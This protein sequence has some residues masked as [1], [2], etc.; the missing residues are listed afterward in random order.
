MN[1][2][3]AAE[4]ILIFSGFCEAATT[5]STVERGLIPEERSHR[6]AAGADDKWFTRFLSPF[7]FFYLQLPLPLPP[8]KCYEVGVKY[9]M[10]DIPASLSTEA[11]AALPVKNIHL[12]SARPVIV[13]FRMNLPFRLTYRRRTQRRKC[14][15]VY[16]SL[17]Q[18]VG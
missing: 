17:L 1:I 5:R 2:Q 4:R 16:G 10:V 13:L 8:L 12:Q 11:R 7:P 15:E 3:P 18:Y 14:T 9:P 6:D